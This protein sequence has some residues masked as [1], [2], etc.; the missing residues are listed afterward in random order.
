MVARGG[1]CALCCCC[2]YWP[3]LSHHTQYVF[4]AYVRVGSSSNIQNTGLIMS[5]WSDDTMHDTPPTQL[6]TMHRVY[7]VYLTIFCG[8]R[9][10]AVCSSDR[11]ARCS[12]PAPSAAASTCRKRR[13]HPPRRNCWQR[14]PRPPAAERP[15][16]AGVQRTA[17][18]PAAGSSATRAIP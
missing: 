11:R 8:W 17:P 3:Q 5:H 18:I 7:Q 10:H 9:G 13:A 4:L 16:I 6:R 12:A 2:C 1:C 15:A 14:R